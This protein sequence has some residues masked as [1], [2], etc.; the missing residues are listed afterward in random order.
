MILIDSALATPAL[1][2]TLT[3]LRPHVLH[4]AI[5]HR[6]VRHVWHNGGPATHLGDAHRL[7]AR[8]ARI[9][10]GRGGWR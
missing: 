9:D 10:A 4:Q 8:R 6:R 3:G 5:G 7:A 1:V 2:S